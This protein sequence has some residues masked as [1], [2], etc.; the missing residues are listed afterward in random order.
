MWKLGNALP[1]HMKALRDRQSTLQSTFV[2][3]NQDGDGEGD[4]LR[5]GPRMVMTADAGLQD[6]YL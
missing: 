2:N 5:I 1:L 6:E 3:A 4:N